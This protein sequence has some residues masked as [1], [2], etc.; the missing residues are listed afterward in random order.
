[1][2]SRHVPLDNDQRALRDS[3]VAGRFYAQL[4]GIGQ[5]LVIENSASPADTRARATIQLFTCE[6]GVGRNGLF[7]FTRVG[8]N[9]PEC[10]RAAQTTRSAQSTASYARAAA[11]AFAKAQVPGAGGVGDAQG[12]PGASVSANSAP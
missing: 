3:G 12:W 1:M 9:G 11:P 6:T 4:S 8:M 2:R 5:F 10:E 7:P